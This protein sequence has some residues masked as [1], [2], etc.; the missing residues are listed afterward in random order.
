MTIRLKAVLRTIE[1][2]VVTT[3]HS[4]SIRLERR[5]IFHRSCELLTRPL[6]TSPD[7]QAQRVAPWRALSVRH[8]CKQTRR[9]VQPCS[10]HHALHSESLLRDPDDVRRI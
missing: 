5:R 3:P 10:P 6:P 8:R 9:F 7:V 2:T 4:K 1:G